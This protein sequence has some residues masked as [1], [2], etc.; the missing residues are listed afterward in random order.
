MIF[1]DDRVGSRELM[2]FLPPQLAQITRLQFGDAMWLGNGPEGPLHIGVEVKTLGDLLR[3]IV[4]GRFAGH[5]L[6]GLI[7]DYHVVYVV[8]EGRYRP[9]KDSG[10]LQVPW[11]GAWADADFGAKRWMHRDLDG[12]LTTMEM[13]FNIKVRKTFDRIE[14]ARVIQDLH[15][16]WTDKEWHEHHSG[17]TFDTS[18]EPALLPASVMCRIAAQ[19]KGIGWKRAHAVEKH[20]S[21][22]I[23]MILAP[24][25]EWDR[26]PG[27]GKKV[28]AGVVDEIWRQRGQPHG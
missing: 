4:T 24:K 2:R 12:F 11:R 19:L 13:K 21:S 10:I 15:R 9:E 16:W 17:H 14:T 1:I 18:G 27:V 23:D 5:Q 7:R 6:P 3:D 25:E 22:V 8:L 20:F 28:A 26:V